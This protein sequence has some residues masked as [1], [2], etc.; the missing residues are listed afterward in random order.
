MALFSRQ[1]SSNK[2]AHLLTL[3]LR[4]AVP[5]ALLHTSMPRSSPSGDCMHR[6]TVRHL[7]TTHLVGLIANVGMPV[8][9]KP[10]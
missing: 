6:S 5:A 8:M 3:V 2:I 10:Q 9:H 7:S 4:L 1:T